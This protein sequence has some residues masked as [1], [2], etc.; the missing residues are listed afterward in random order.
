[1]VLS[2]SHRL[3][4]KY[5]LV[6]FSDVSYNELVKDCDYVKALRILSVIELSKRYGKCVNKGFKKS[7]GCSKDVYDMFKDELVGLKKEHFFVLLLDTKNRIIKKELV[8]VG[9]LNASLVHPREVFR[10]AIRESANSIILIHNHPS[11]DCSPSDEDVSITERLVEIGCLL[12]VN[13]LDH[14]VVGTDDYWSWKES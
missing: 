11:G 8:S 9:T 12:D 3:L 4:K 2:L 14:V 10:S 6:G 7:I 5:G 13:V 1:G